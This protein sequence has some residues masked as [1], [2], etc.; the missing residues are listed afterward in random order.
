VAKGKAARQQ[1]QHHEGGSK[2]PAQQD[3]EEEAPVPTQVIFPY[4]TFLKLLAAAATR[5]RWVPRGLLNVGNSCYANATMQVWLGC[6]R[7]ASCC[8]G[9][10]ACALSTAACRPFKPP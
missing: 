6:V 4:G 8:C 2:A 1:Q 3:P 9:A 5:R 10:A 7:G